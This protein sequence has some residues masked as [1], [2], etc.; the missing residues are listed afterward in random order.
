VVTDFGFDSVMALYERVCERRR[1]QERLRLPSITCPNCG[2]TS[3]NP[4]DVREGYCGNCHDWTGSP[5]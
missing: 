1:R 4:N 5:P 2:R 3:W